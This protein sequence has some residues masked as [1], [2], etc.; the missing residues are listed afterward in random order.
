MAPDLKFAPTARS[1][2]PVC[3]LLTMGIAS[4]PSSLVGVPAQIPT[5]ACLGPRCAFFH[6]AGACAVFVMAD[7]M[8][9]QAHMMATEGADDSTEDTAGSETPS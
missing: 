6:A 9:A 8:L 3:P 4:P 2:P 5:V 7:A 1:A